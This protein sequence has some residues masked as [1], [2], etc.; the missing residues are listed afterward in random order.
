MSSKQECVVYI[1]EDMTVAQCTAL[2]AKLEHQ[3]GIFEV[4][5][6]DENYHRLT[7]HYD[8]DH[9]S[10]LTLMDLIRLHGNHGKV[11]NA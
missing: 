2:A 4:L 11:L 3:R 10:L 6:D 8:R 7:I 5:F 9:F 1:E